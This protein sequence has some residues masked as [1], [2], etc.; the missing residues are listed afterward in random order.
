MHSPGFDP[1]IMDELEM[2]TFD[3]IMKESL[4]EVDEYEHVIKEAL[5]DWI[6][7]FKW[8]DVSRTRFRKYA[9]TVMAASAVAVVLYRFAAGDVNSIGEGTFLGVILG[10][11]AKY[12]WEENAN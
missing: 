7:L 5:D 11:A 8:G 2:D 3:R 4:N 6:F 12:L 9:A 1:D 10:F